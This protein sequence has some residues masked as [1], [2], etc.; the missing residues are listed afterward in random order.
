MFLGHAQLSD[1]HWVPPIH[2]RSSISLEDYHIY[3]SSPIEGIL[4]GSGREGT[5]DSGWGFT[6][7][8]GNVTGVFGFKATY[9][10]SNL[11]VFVDTSELN[12]VLRDKGLVVTSSPAPIYL[13]LRIRSEFHAGHLTPKGMAA[14]GTSFRLGSIPQG[15]DLG[16]TNFFASFMATEDNTTV[17]ISDY[18]SNVVFAGPNAQNVGSVTFTFDKEETYVVSGYTNDV[19]N[20]NGFIGALV[21]SNKPIAVN[22]GN[23]LG[24]FANTNGARDFAMDQVVPVDKVGKSYIVIEG[25]GSADIERPMVIATEPNT[26]V[27]VNEA[28]VTVLNDAGDHVLIDNV[29][30]QG[31]THRNMYISSSKDVYVYQFLAG[32]AN[33]E[34]VGMNFI[35]PLSCSFEKELN[36]IPFVDEIGE[37]FYE[38]ALLVVTKT[39]A[40]LKV[41]DEEVTQEPESVVG[42]PN[43]VTYRLEGYTGNVSIVSTEPLSAGLIGFNSSAGFAGHYSGFGA[44]HSEQETELCDNVVTELYTKIDDA[45]EEAGVW[46]NPNGIMHS[47]F[48]DPNT[49][50]TGIYNYR[51]DTD[52][53]IVEVELDVSNIVVAKNSGGDNSITVC[54]TDTSFNLYDMLEGQ[55]DIGGIWQNAENGETFN[56][57]FDPSTFTS[58][59]YSYGFPEN[60]PCDAVEAVIDVEVVAEIDSIEAVLLS[61]QLA[62]NGS[63]VQVNTIGG[64]GNFEYRIDGGPWQESPIFNNLNNGDHVI[65]MRD[66]SGCNPEFTTTIYTLSYPTFFTPNGDS[67][68]DTWK[69]DGLDISTSSEIYIF[70]RY[71]K[72]L[73]QIDPL[74][75]GW[76][77]TYLGHN[78]PSDDYWFKILYT[79]R[80]GE[81]K[82]FVAHFTL[83]R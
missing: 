7:P 53:G 15:S 64:V 79:N 47:G 75:E 36:R 28:L 56:G 38:T 73:K 65:T 26:E 16:D 43:W 45:P 27:Y 18:D 83:K 77:G 81:R 60:P 14:L 6:L 17:T 34:T 2:S 30:Y 22:T 72:L 11:S 50:I 74:E 67:Y 21:T 19:A 46:T 5:S 69:I 55:P 58:G 54:E 42:N 63:S 78:L 68:N 39:G 44:G 12:T 71:G 82:G 4:S 29:H 3:V 59:I 51:A 62:K 10:G 31:I 41:N 37:E 66:D 8:F 24:S 70:N 61:P 25:K 40:T 1:T 32:D 33:P 23:A 48:F 49:D 80:D 13:S 35:P 57:N 20:Y 52:C 76:D 9:R